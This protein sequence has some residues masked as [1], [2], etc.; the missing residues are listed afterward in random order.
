MKVR[1]F[2]NV[3]LSIFLVLFLMVF[4]YVLVNRYNVGEGYVVIV[5]F[6][7]RSFILLFIWFILMVFVECNYE[8][9]E[10]EEE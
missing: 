1:N 8:M 2:F 4:C 3:V 10:M 5:N 9:N 6:S 7:E